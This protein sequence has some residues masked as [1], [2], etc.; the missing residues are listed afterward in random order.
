MA[1]AESITPVHAVATPWLGLKGDSSE[2]LFLLN[3]NNNSN[4]NCVQRTIGP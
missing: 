3:D 2:T 4:N 1:I